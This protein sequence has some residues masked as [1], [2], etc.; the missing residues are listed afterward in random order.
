MIGACYAEINPSLALIF[1]LG[2]N[3]S[4]ASKFWMLYVGIHTATKY[5]QQISDWIPNRWGG[6]NRCTECKSPNGL[7]NKLTSNWR[8]A[9]GF[10]TCEVGYACLWIDAGDLKVK[11]SQNRWPNKSGSIVTFIMLG[12]VCVEKISQVEWVDT[13]TVWIHSMED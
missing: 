3:S 12:S 4:V 9:D 2:S 13:N 10:D 7:M 1:K 11:L 5:H 6:K 8:W